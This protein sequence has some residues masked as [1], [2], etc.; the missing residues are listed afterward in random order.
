MAVLRLY[1]G[2]LRVAARVAADP[3][4]CISSEFA[5]A[6]AAHTASSVLLLV[7]VCPQASGGG[8]ATSRP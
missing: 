1:E 6:A 7:Y 3:G 5:T 8:C 4:T 2:F